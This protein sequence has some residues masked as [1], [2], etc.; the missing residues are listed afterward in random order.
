MRHKKLT[1]LFVILLFTG[2]SK[3]KQE[4]PA[5]RMVSRIDYYRNDGGSTTLDHT[6]KFRYDGQNRITE[7]IITDENY[8]KTSF[9]SYG[10]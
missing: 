9:I 1:A 10:K 5:M 4:S 3:D 8:V 7:I 6:N 2:C